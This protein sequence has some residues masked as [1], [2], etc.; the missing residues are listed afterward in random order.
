MRLFEAPRLHVDSGTF[1]E[2][3]TDADLCPYEGRRSVTGLLV[4]L[5]V[6]H[7]TTISLFCHVLSA[8][9]ERVVSWKLFFYFWVLHGVF[10]YHGLALEAVLISS[11]S[12][13]MRRQSLRSVENLQNALKW[14][15]GYV[16]A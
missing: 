12:I 16:P 11:A 7:F 2:Y 3:G 15:F 1:E 13:L 14:F 8:R 9:R 4:K 6:A 10:F 5:F